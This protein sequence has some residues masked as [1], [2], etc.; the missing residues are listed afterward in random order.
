MN[1]LSIPT[2]CCRTNTW[3]YPG[4]GLTGPQDS[5]PRLANESPDNSFSEVMW[6]S[7]KEHTQRS[8]QAYNE[9]LH[10]FHKIHAIHNITTFESKHLG[11]PCAPRSK[12][13]VPLLGTLPF[14]A[15][16]ASR[17][18]SRWSLEGWCSSISNEKWY[19]IH[20]K[21]C[22][23]LNQMW[24]LGFFQA[25]CITNIPWPSSCLRQ[26]DGDAN[27]LQLQ[28][29]WMSH[30][31]SVGLDCCGLHLSQP[32]WFTIFCTAILYSCV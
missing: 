3:S 27:Q 12:P 15:G 31:G 5:T 16:R 14:P 22:F 21:N 2:S 17:N 9:S 1:P 10:K 23:I 19:Q 28:P 11:M 30:S 32:W 18:S 26:P 8:I 25:V 7:K 29:Q 6:P 20:T 24:S 4:S 13:S